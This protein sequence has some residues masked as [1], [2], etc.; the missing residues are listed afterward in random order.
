MGETYVTVTVSNPSEPERA[1]TGE[2]LAD[3]GATLSVVPRKRLEEIGIVPTDDRFAEL[4]DGS[5]IRL[6]V[7]VAGLEFVG[8]RTLGLVIFGSDDAEPQLGE[9]AMLGVGVKVDT[10][11]HCLEPAKIRA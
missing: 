7:A 8:E 5:V 2:F 4:A 3:T 10:V 9:T 11:N 6:E 1:W